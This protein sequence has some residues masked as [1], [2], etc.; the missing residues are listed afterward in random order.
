MN[1]TKRK[2]TENCKRKR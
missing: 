1:L 2:D